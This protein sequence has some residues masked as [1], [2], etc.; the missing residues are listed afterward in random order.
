MLRTERKQTNEKLDK[1]YGVMRIIQQQSDSYLQTMFC[2]FSLLIIH[3]SNFCLYCIQD[4][5]G[6]VCEYTSL[7]YVVFTVNTT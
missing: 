1:E 6:D 4:I 3:V 7:F 2:L 5:K